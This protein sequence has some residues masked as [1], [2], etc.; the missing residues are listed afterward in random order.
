MATAENR[1]A[2][3][4]TVSNHLRIAVFGPLIA[5]YRGVEIPISNRKAQALL[6]YLVLSD[7]S[8]DTRERLMGLLWSD[9][10]PEKARGSLRNTL[11]DLSKAFQAAGLDHFTTDR[12]SK[13]V[14]R[15]HM[16]TDLWDV[17]EH[18]KRGDV[19]ALLLERDRITETM[20]AGLDHLDRSFSSWLQAKRQSLHSR[21]TAALEDGL[22]GVT[23]NVAPGNAEHL[24]RALANLDPTHEEAARVLIQARAA[25][26]DL[27]SAFGIYDALWKLLDE[28]YDI[29]PSK[30]TQD[31]IALLRMSQPPTIA[32][33]MGLLGQQ[34]AT[35]VLPA[36]PVVPQAPRPQKLIL[37]LGGFD[38]AGVKP[39]NRY[40]VQGFRSELAACLVRFREW[41][42]RD[43]PTISAGLSPS[44]Q[45]DGE[46]I[47]DASAFEASEGLRLV[48]MLRDAATG[49]YVW[50]ERLQLSVEEWFETQNQVVRRLATALNVNLSAERLA[51]ITAPRPN[52]SQSSY[53]SWL[54]A[55]AYTYSFSF[56]NW[57]RATKIY[58]DIVEKNPMFA[59]AHVGLAN[60]H[61]TV[62]LAHPGVVRDLRRS[63]EALSYAESASKLEPINSRTQLCLGWSH[64][65]CGSF[66]QAELSF[67]L[68]FELNDADPWTAVSSAQGIAFCGSARRGRARADSALSAVTSPSKAQWAF[69]VGTRFLDGDYEGC[70]EAAQAAGNQIPNLGG[71]KSASLS[72]LGRDVAAQ[73]EAANFF[74]FV[75][76]R[77]IIDAP[78]DDVAITRWFL[79]L[80]PIK[81]VADWNRLRDGLARCGAPVGELQHGFWMPSPGEPV[82]AHCPIE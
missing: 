13:W 55:Q 2:R 3:D 67:D 77:W 26:G 14:D 74:S 38:A 5:T 25:A 64:A 4:P 76:Q 81:Q 18:A 27:G 1:Q 53:D 65:M 82:Q 39:E 63:Q 7:A 60:Q 11:Y 23:P 49:E 12:F 36:P 21:L 47:V 59:S 75:R 15:A 10:E 41:S 42:V 72:L 66:D 6:G 54:Q 78:A 71:W 62:H 73:A 52:H 16:E 24:A 19:H 46:Y 50:S 45:H 8:E 56:E 32:V 9:A 48:L 31:L 34:R 30:P 44:A 17:M 61:N 37:N 80:F 57:H 43:Q 58:R 51:I 40:L 68:A 69:N 33:P 29:E 70:V 79:Q 35:V 20:L 22:R 28:D